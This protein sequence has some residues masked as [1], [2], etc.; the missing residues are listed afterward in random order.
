[1][2]ILIVDD[3]NDNQYMLRS[4]LIG[5]GY[6]VAEGANGKEAM[7]MIDKGDIDLIVSD[8]LMPVMDG[9]SLCWEVKKNPALRSIPFI[10][11]TA[12]YTGTQDEALAVELG[13]DSFII[14]PCEPD[15]LIKTIQEVYGKS[16]QKK[17]I[18][19]P[20][21]QTEEEILKLYNERLVRKLEQKMLQAEEDVKAKMEALEALHRSEALLNATQSISKIGGWEWNIENQEMFW[22]E[23]TLKIH[24]LEPTNGIFEGQE[25]IS[26]SIFCYA[27]D[28][29]PRI[30]DAF[31]DCIEEGIPYE[32]ECKFTTFKGRD[33]YIRTAGKPLY[34]GDKI[35]KVLGSIQDITES[36]KNELERIELLEQ[37][38]KT[39]RLDSIGQLAGGVAHDFNNILAV[40]LGYSEEILA[41][42]QPEDPIFKDMEEIVK[43]G[44]KA[45]SLTRQLLTFSRKHVFQPQ[46]INLN[47]AIRDM[48]KMLG[49]LV[50]EDIELTS[51]MAGDL[52]NIKVDIAQIEQVLMN[53]VINARE[54]MPSGG[55]LFIETSNV[56]IEQ[57]SAETDL[58][59]EPGEYVLLSITDTGCGMDK[60]T[61]NRI[62]EPFFTTKHNNLG[63]GLGLSTVYGIVNQ[64]E[65][66]IKVDTEPGKGT[67]FAIFFPRT[68]E[69]LM[70]ELEENDA[71]E[72]YGNGEH[73]VVVEDDTAMGALTKKMLK[74]LGYRITLFENSEEAILNIVEGGL[75]PDLVI[76]DVVMPGI[77]GKELTDAIHKTLP[78][79]KVIFMS[80][81]TDSVILEHGVMN[82]DTSY[83]Q[84]PFS[85]ESIAKKIKYM[86]KIKTNPNS[87]IAHILM[88]DDDENILTIYSRAFL[89]RGHI[90]TGA[91]NLKAA[92]EL[93]AKQPFVVILVDMNIPGTD[94]ISII[95]EIRKAGYST[96]A[97]IVSGITGNI[98]LQALSALGEAKLF[99]KSQDI[100]PL[101]DEI[102][103]LL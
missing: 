30:A 32:L 2:K 76:T 11:Y 60:E 15:V 3:N 22:T 70:P 75:V 48:T 23:E 72:L 14:K 8:I 67:T 38:R 49:R 74:K 86:L 7:E 5:N 64:S 51:Q 37:L 73:I 102:E 43:S 42:L 19:I 39:Q 40:I 25:I 20:L 96:P 12:T 83:I 101:I 98:D 56:V 6:V 31:I 55:R 85:K 21:L 97:F 92:L 93:L 28:D 71:M 65:G 68:D 26:K 36:K 29:R 88:I 41:S 82:R 81:Y 47:N 69:E 103:G 63:T 52:G 89:Q 78:E 34:E 95:T 33:L 58:G 84:K 44:K 46:I 94:G 99:E 35:V 54:A 13:A 66:I 10:I 17:D 1:M 59:L 91:S 50:G 4:L 27:V 45:L 90:L 57:S 9:F 18:D 79:L 87:K 62:F 24:E 16:K 77:N 53:L 100:R 80:G 61:S